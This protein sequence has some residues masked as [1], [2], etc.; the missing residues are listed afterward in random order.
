M[1]RKWYNIVKYEKNAN[2]NKKGKVEEHYYPFSH[3]FNAKAKTT[4]SYFPISVNIFICYLQLATETVNYT[5]FG[6]W[7]QKITTN[8]GQN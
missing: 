7:Q 5:L 2:Q 3:K 8:K 1:R 6:I 4:I